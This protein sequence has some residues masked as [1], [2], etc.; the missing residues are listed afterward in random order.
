[1]AKYM[2]DTFKM[3]ARTAPLLKIVSTFDQ[4]CAPHF[5]VCLHRPAWT[6]LNRNAIPPLPTAGDNYFADHTDGGSDLCARALE[7]HPAWQ[8]VERRRYHPSGVAC[9]PYPSGLTSGRIATPMQHD[10]ATLWS[11]A[12][13]ATR[14]SPQNPNPQTWWST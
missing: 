11:L 13:V 9:P 6:G 14:S 12:L 2:M 10:G 5:G 8:S 1:M 3:Q 4:P 7:T